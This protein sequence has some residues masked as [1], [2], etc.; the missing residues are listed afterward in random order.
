[1]RK[2]YREK[3]IPR[4]PERIRGPLNFEALYDA[5]G[6]KLEGCST[7][8]ATLPPSIRRNTTGSTPVPPKRSHAKLPSQPFGPQWYKINDVQI[9]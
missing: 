6:G 2:F 4:V 8:H 1:M 5:F 7:L 3:V 9:C